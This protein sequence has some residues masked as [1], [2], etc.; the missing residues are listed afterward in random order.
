MA[1][2]ANLLSHW[3]G[4]VLRG[5]VAS[6][7]ARQAQA[8]YRSIVDAL[9]VL[10]RDGQVLLAWR[11]GTGYADG[12]W[13]LPSG[14]LEDGEIVS[15]AAVREAREEVDVRIAGGD[16][17]FVHLM[18]YRNAQGHARIGVFFQALAWEGEP[19]NAEPGKCERI[20]WWPLGQL[21]A[22]TYPY[23]AEG[24]RAYVGGELY[25]AGRM[26]RRRRPADHSVGAAHDRWSVVIMGWCSA[27]VPAECHAS[28]PI[29]SLA[30]PAR[31]F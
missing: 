17:R 22:G 29:R 24:I 9:I 15:Q 2:A 20:G 13:N 7:G 14:K 19:C 18:H 8:P 6:I 16:L 1:A 30:R 4:G 12:A 11:R 23:T 10:L 26:A 25:S 27:Q 21:P 28:W 5:P 3:T 31:S